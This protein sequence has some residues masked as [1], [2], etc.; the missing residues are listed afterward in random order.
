MRGRTQCSRDE[1]RHDWRH[2]WRTRVVRRS[3][4]TWPQSQQRSD[5]VVVLIRWVPSN[6]IVTNWV[7]MHC[8]TCLFQCILLISCWYWSLFSLSVHLDVKLWTE[9]RSMSG[10][11]AHLGQ[12]RKA[13]IQVKVQ[14]TRETSAIGMFTVGL[15]WLTLSYD[16]NKHW[17]DEG[18]FTLNIMLTTKY[19]DVLVIS[20]VSSED[21]LVY[22][23]T[24]ESYFCKVKT[25]T[26]LET[27]SVFVKF[28]DSFIH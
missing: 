14:V 15:W 9:W 24:S 23:L 20:A 8:T 6:C 19:I 22:F 27:T 16:R 26:S 17:L 11:L 12:I 1:L 10:M 2:E 18:Y 21:S 5:A 28:S 7:S 13:R 25:C 4:I 3:L